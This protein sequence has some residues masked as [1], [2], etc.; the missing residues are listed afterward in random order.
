MCSRLQ[1]QVGEMERFLGDYGLQWVGEPADDED[2]EDQSDSE[3]GKR[4]WMTA[5][6]LWKPGRV[7][8]PP[9]TPSTK[10]VPQHPP[11]GQQLCRAH[12][13]HP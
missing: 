9:P 2:S 4:D 3:D 10:G 8:G 11:L 5:K 6:K 1:R 12:L 13:I 7:G